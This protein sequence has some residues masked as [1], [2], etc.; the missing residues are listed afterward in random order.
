[1]LHE[2]I[3]KHSKST[4]AIMARDLLVKISLCRGEQVHLELDKYQTPSIK[5][6]ER[7]L[8]YSGTTKQFIITGPDQA[9]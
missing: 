8:R 2:T 9:Q 1:M 4:Y 3:M 6:A 7:N 5:D